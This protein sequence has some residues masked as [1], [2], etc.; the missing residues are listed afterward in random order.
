[1]KTGTILNLKKTCRTCKW[2]GKVRDVAT[3]GVGGQCFCPDCRNKM[4]LSVRQYEA[5]LELSARARI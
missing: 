5:L 1:M 3:N 4:P 2:V